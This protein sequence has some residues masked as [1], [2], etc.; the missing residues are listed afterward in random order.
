MIAFIK[1]FLQLCP[2][3]KGYVCSVKEKSNIKNKASL[4]SA[5][6]LSLLLLIAP[7]KVR[8]HIEETLGIKQTEVSNKIQATSSNLTCHSFQIAKIAKTSFKLNWPLSFALNA[9][10]VNDTS[11]TIGRVAKL[12]PIFIIQN[13]SLTSIARYILYQNLKIAL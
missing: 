5:M 4:L 1:K 9:L 11:K 13:H 8:N 12:G 7:C 6:M 2:H 3:F 10:K